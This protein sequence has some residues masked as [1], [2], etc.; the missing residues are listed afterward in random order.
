[1]RVKLNYLDQIVK[2]WEIQGF[3]LKIFNVEWW[4]L[5]FYSF[6]KIVVEEGGYE[7]ICKDCWW[8]WVVQC[9]NYLLGKNIG[10]LLCFY[11]ECI[12]Y[13]YEMY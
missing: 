5:D 2:F 8:V 7:V 4:I 12:V 3:F 10:F 11:Y 13:F 1:M 9:F 6:S